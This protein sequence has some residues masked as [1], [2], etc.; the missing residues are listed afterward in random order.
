MRDVKENAVSVGLIYHPI[1][2]EHDTG[3]H[4]EVSLRL[5]T[6]MSHLKNVGTI[7]K[8]IPIK[9]QAATVE[10]IA[11]VHSPSYISGIESFVKHGGGYLDGDTVA[12]SFSYEAAIYAAGG[13]IS[14]VDAVMSSDVTYSDRKSVVRERVSP[15]V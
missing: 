4:C 9:P 5:T 12:S 15:S 1:Y 7:D 10:Q 14:A 6:T 13:V 8:L 11:R 2:L 3:L